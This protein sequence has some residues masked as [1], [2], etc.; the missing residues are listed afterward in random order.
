MVLLLPD[1]TLPHLAP[2]WVSLLT[3]LETLPASCGFTGPS[4]DS[5]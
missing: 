2:S 3:E 1:P 5:N 4:G